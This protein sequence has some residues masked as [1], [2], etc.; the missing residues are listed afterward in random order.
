MFGSME[1]LEKK[2]EKMEEFGV[3]LREY[4]NRVGQFAQYASVANMNLM[5]KAK[6]ALEAWV[7]KLLREANE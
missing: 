1:E 2:V 4:K 7:D 6:E 3:L 5:D